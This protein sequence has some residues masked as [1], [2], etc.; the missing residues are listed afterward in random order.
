VNRQLT[1]TMVQKLGLGTAVASNGREAV[2]RLE[3]ET[4][5]MVLMDVQM[6]EVDGLTATRRW[7]ER[8]KEL[9]RPRTLIVAL[10]A[11]A[12]PQDKAACLDSGMDDYM[13]KPLRREALAEMITRHLSS[14]TASHGAAVAVPSR[15]QGE[16]TTI[17]KRPVSGLTP[18]MLSMLRDSNVEGLGRVRTGIATGD[19]LEVARALHFVKGGC[20]LLQDAELTALLRTLELEAKAGRLT[21]VSRRLPELEVQIETVM[22]RAESGIGG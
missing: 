15:S 9:G 1:E 22:R 7:R 11:H 18:T 2:E 10:T 8:E 21:E 13:C 14:R 3:K 17:L 6:P 12:L 19:G 20:A 5:S 16:S 4:F